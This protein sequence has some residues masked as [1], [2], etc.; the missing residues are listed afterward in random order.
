VTT[1]S[2]LLAGWLTAYREALRLQR[3]HEK[4]A[5]VDCALTL[6]VARAFVVAEPA[7]LGTPYGSRADL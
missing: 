7:A 2:V 3:T 5:V 1:A 4:R 6:L